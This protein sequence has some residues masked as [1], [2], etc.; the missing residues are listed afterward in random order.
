M[1]F[2]GDVI[3]A[4]QGCD[5]E[6]CCDGGWVL[7]GCVTWL[8]GHGCTQETLP[9]RADGLDAPHA[10]AFLASNSS[11]IESLKIMESWSVLSWEDLQDY[12]VT[13][14]HSNH[15]NFHHLFPDNLTNRDT[16]VQWPALL[17]WEQRET[18]HEPH[19]RAHSQ[20]CHSHGRKEGKIERAYLPS[21]INEE[22]G[23]EQIA[24]GMKSS[25]VLTRSLQPLFATYFLEGSV[26]IRKRG[27]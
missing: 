11:Q 7:G 24:E 22:D 10:S 13:T 16:A 25:T 14:I 2:S 5:P 15:S 4:N 1:G 6:V 19:R 26:K 12:L 3:I 21:L 20:A 27:L 18:W 23:S 9:C 8:A 17:S